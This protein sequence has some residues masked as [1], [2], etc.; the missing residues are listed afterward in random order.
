MNEKIAA[1]HRRN[2]QLLS[3]LLGIK[4]EIIAI[5]LDISQQ[6]VSKLEKKAQ[7]N[8]EILE[9]VAKV[10]KIPVVAIK[11]FNQDKLVNVIA[12]TSSESEQICY[13]SITR[14]IDKLIEMIERLLKVEQEKNALLEKI[15]AEKK[16]S[17]K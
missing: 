13:Q 4:Q 12:N 3:Y 16:D 7:I 9:K 8:D 1:H 10:L 11:S 2:I 5:E 15:V 17:N 6:A 14:Q